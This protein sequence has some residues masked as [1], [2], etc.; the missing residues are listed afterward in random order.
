[1]GPDG[2][3]DR[4]IAEDHVQITQGERSG[5]GTKL[6]YTADDGHFVL[7]GTAA[8]PPRITDPQHG[9]VSGSSLIFNDR[10]DSVVVSHGQSPTMTDTR[11]S[12][13]RTKAGTVVGLCRS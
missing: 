13:R 8:A 3:V 7:T 11:T 9:T 12:K 5:S 10:D 4:L 2:Q 6:V 1:M